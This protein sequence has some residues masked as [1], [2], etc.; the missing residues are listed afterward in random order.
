MNID[1]KIPIYY[2]PPVYVARIWK[3][4]HLQGPY[5]GERT[6]ETNLSVALSV[7]LIIYYNNI[8]SAWPYPYNHTLIDLYCI[9]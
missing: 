8:L 5:C 7:K 6:S 4:S 9:W 3:F 1:K 2:L